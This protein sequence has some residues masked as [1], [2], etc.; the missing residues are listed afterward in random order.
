MCKEAMYS[1]A[2]AKED[3]NA[4]LGYGTDQGRW[5]VDQLGGKETEVVRRPSRQPSRVFHD[6]NDMTPPPPPMNHPGPMEPFG[7]QQLYNSATQQMLEVVQ[8]AKAN[9]E[10]MAIIAAVAF[11]ALAAFGLIVWVLTR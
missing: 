2:K 6:A 11:V 7:L 1:E 8:F 4:R 10:D 3:Y 9:P 5:L